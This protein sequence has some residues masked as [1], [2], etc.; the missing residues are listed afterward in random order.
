VAD[1]WESHVAPHGPLVPLAADLWQVTGTGGPLD[2]NMV[3]WR[4][5]SGGLWLHSVVALDAAGMAALDALGPVE[6][7]VVPNG[8]HRMDCAVYAARYPAAKVVAPAAARKAV[9]EKTPV[10]ATCEDALPAL[11]IR[12]HVPVGA[13]PGELAYELPIASGRALVVSDLLFNLVRSPGGLKGFFLTYVTS[14]VG[15]LKVSRVFRMLAMA[16]RA[17][18]AGWVRS[19]ADVADLRVLCVGHGDAVTGDVSAQVRAAADRI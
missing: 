8:F 4:T 16:D 11:G 15:P 12:V 10:H 1:T 19:L 18:Y 2:R 14:S 9:E 7:I 6:W 17:A 5:P 3:V 13:K